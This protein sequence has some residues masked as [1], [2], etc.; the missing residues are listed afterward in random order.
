MAP[1]RRWHEALTSRAWGRALFLLLCV[2]PLIA[3]VLSRFKRH[4]LWFSDYDAVACAGEKMAQGED[5]YFWPP[6]CS[7]HMHSSGYVYPPFV[8]RMFETG[9]EAIGAD[10]FK[11]AYLV[12]AAISFCFLCWFVFLRREA[13]A[14]FWDRALGFALV[15]GSLVYYANIAVPLHAL[16][17][18]A[19]LVAPRRPWVFALA[20]AAAAALKP[21][22]LV[23]GLVLLVVQAPL[24]TRL[25]TGAVAATLGLAPTAAFVIGGGEV[26]ATWRRSLEYFVY[27]RQPGE[28]F[29]GWLFAFGLDGRGLA[30]A[31]ACALYVGVMS[32]AAIAIAIKAKLDGPARVSL[33]LGI[34][35]LVNPRLSA[36]DVLPLALA[37]GSVIAVARAADLPERTRRGIVALVAGGLCIGGIGNSLDL[38]DYCVKVCTVMLSAA[39]LWLAVALVRREPRRATAD[40]ITSPSS[41]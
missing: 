19:A 11:I 10:A 9:V 38:G 39:V 14:G 1:M 35:C 29:Y 3:G 33:G 20:L 30:F 37:A 18:L 21:V 23:Y 7:H 22:Y 28:G 31:A 27:G 2:A 24:L 32:L 13:P 15:T 26:V 5:F 17:F 6:V 36:N 12:V 16:I 34:A 41:A 40:N 8:A 25:A 4:S